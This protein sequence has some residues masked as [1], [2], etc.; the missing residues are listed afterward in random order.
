MRPGELY[1]SLIDPIWEKV[2]IHGTPDLF[3]HQFGKLTEPQQHL[4]ASHW[5]QSEV[6]NG[7]FFQFFENSTGMLAPEAVAGFRAIGLE[8][9]AAL[10]EEAMRYFGSPYPREREDRNAKLQD[11]DAFTKLDDQFFD[12]I[13]NDGY[14]KAAD[15][16]ASRTSAA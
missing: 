15:D 6:R 3:L 5:C 11:E 13:A 14:D 8:P 16:F 2:S 12:A 1:W 7:G 10:L 9:C 4:F